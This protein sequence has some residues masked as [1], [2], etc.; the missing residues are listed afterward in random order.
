MIKCLVPCTLCLLFLAAIAPANAD[1][2]TPANPATQAGHMAHPSAG[3]RIQHSWR[4]PARPRTAAGHGGFLGR[5]HLQVSVIPVARKRPALHWLRPGLDKFSVKRVFASSFWRR[6]RRFALDEAAPGPPGP[7]L[8]IGIYEKVM[9]LDLLPTALLKALAVGDVERARALGC[10]EL[11]E[12][13]LALCG[14]VCPG[15]TSYGESLRQVL[16]L[17]EAEG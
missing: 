5:Y 6:R 1:D 4:H 11:D 14:F 3:I 16:G 9:P 8:P 7:I 10:L 13:D 2:L 12:E 15:K 17:I